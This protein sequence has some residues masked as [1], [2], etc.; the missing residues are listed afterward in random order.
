MLKGLGQP[1]RVHNRGQIHDMAHLNIHLDC[2]V[3]I[4]K[5]FSVSS[6]L[7]PLTVTALLQAIP[8]P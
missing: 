8:L 2:F 6:T 4:T 1:A 5:V 7:R 3:F